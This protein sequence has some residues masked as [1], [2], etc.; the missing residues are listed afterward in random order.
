MAKNNSGELLKATTVTIID[1]LTHKR[2]FFCHIN[3]FN[4]KHLCK[5]ELLVG[6]FKY[7][8]RRFPIWLRIG[9]KYLSFP[10]VPLGISA[11]VFLVAV[12]FLSIPFYRL[13]LPLYTNCPVAG[14]LL[15]GSY[16]ATGGC[17][18]AVIP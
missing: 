12:A 8:K 10:P 7:V 5:R 1:T 9:A 6:F 13:L 14:K 16:L 11:F 3:F 4:G 17:G 2:L 18:V 15:V